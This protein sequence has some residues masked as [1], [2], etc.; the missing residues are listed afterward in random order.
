MSLE[1]GASDYPVTS[2]RMYQ[3][4][5]C[6]IRVFVKEDGTA[7]N[8]SVSKST[9]FAP[10]DQAVCLAIQKAPFVPARS[11]GKTVGA[12]TDINIPWRLSAK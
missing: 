12:F 7:S 3:E 1:V 4:G 5:D 6:T 9:G 11:N 8:M 10:L 2:R